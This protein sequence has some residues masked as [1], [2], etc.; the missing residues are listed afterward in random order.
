MMEPRLHAL[1]R[2]PPVG[3]DPPARRAARP[4]G[5]RPRALGTLVWPPPR[6]SAGEGAAPPGRS[7]AGR[8]WPGG[9][10]DRAMPGA[11]PDEAGIG[12]APHRIENDASDRICPPPNPAVT[13]RV[14][15]TP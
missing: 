15:V 14:A 10:R 9:R 3:V 2:S 13:R 4:P 11:R 8:R 5:E 12:E 1:T 7:D 6:A